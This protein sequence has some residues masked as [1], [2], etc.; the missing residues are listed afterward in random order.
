MP[1]SLMRVAQESSY[2]LTTL[3][4]VGTSPKSLTMLVWTC[5]IEKDEKVC[6][7]IH[8]NGESFTKYREER[9]ERERE[10]EEHLQQRGDIGIDNVRLLVGE[11]VEGCGGVEVVSDQQ[12]H[13]QHI[14]PLRAVGQR[15]G[16]MLRYGLVQVCDRVCVKKC[17][18]KC[19]VR[20]SKRMLAW[21]VCMRGG[22]CACECER[23][24]AKARTTPAR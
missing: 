10:R 15:E 11:E 19:D 7:S 16:D 3:W 6:V 8:V 4:R 18:Y 14:G 20:E 9:R 5:E 21:G 24:Q 22:E 1:Y 12:D 2:D 17:L 13:V 23:Q